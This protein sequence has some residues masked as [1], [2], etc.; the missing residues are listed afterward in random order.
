MDRCACVYNGIGERVAADMHMAG[1]DVR[2]EYH[3]DIMGD[4][5]N[6]LMHEQGEA[7]LTGNDAVGGEMDDFLIGPVVADMAA[8]W[9][10]IFGCRMVTQ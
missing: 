7:C 10:I 1:T 8:K 5:H 2:T 6:L 9:Q 3:T 4:C